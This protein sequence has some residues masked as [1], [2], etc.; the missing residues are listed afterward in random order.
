MPQLLSLEGWQQGVR[1]AWRSARRSP[2][3]F[4]LAVLIVGL[5]IAASTTVFSV[6]SPLLIRPLP[7]EDAERLVLVEN[8]R[9]GEGLAGVASR[10]SNLRDFR[11]RARSFEALGA[12]N[13]FSNQVGYHLLGSGGPERLR[14]AEVTANFLDVIGVSPVIG[15][16]FT[17]EEG[18]LG[19]E[20]PWPNIAKVVILSHALWLRRFG[21]D[22]SVVGSTVNINGVGREVVGILPEDFD[23]SEIFTP[24]RPV[25]ILAPW[26]VTDFGEEF[27]NTLT[28]V[29]RLRPGASVR[30]AQAELGVTLAAL[31]SEDPDRRDLAAVVSGLQERISRPHRPAL[32][33]LGAAAALLM[34]MVCANLSGLFLARSPGR[35]REMAVRQA[36][37]ATR[38]RL[39]RQLLVE[40]L[41]ITLVGATVGVAWAIVATHFV[42]GWS[43]LDMPMLSGVSVNR[44]AL[45]FSATLATTAAIAVG[46]VPA[47]QVSESGGAAVLS[48][49]RRGSSAGPRSQR[50]R[51]I[52]IVAEVAIACVLLVFGGLIARS[53]HE[54]T[55]VHPGFEAENLIAWEI[56]ATEGFGFAAERWSGYYDGIIR[57]VAA[58]PG[59]QA[60]SFV[61]ILPM[62]GNR[63]SEGTIVGMSYDEGES[64]SFFPRIVDHRYLEV[65]GIPL[66]EGRNFT[67]DDDDEATLVTI[68]NE[69]AARRWF[70][71]APA[72]GKHLDYWRGETEVIGIVADV[73]H[74]GLELSSGAE[75]YFPF[76]QALTLGTLHLVVRTSLP[77]ASVIEAV[78]TAIHDADPL[79]PTDEF[80]TLASVVAQTTSSRRFT[81][82]VLVA[83]TLSALLLAALG[84]YAVFSQV[85]SERR[86]EISIRMALGASSSDVRT[87]LLLQSGRLSIIGV[88]LGVGAA[89][90]TAQ[91]A[92]HVL[93]R[94]EPADPYTIA[95]AIVALATISIGSTFVPALRA[96]R[97]ESARVLRDQGFV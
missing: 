43:G 64:E 28:M 2:A 9:P 31:A 89:V 67:P 42:S 58:V 77:P 41:S 27:G 44:D 78:R 14:A 40:S 49:G 87:S 61:D 55:A 45:L 60:A 1:Q 47:L 72:I 74:R 35:A 32:L 51:E 33:L 90:A 11:E 88:V 37:G 71:G 38:A 3:F 7:L 34:I 91:L 94:V 83:F 92:D 6:M 18:Q 62:S 12:F 76:P 84:I 17:E 23:F 53:F 97:T 65:M 57:S 16:N 19:P 73:K 22:P 59:V 26:P 96:S 82:Q 54:V 24:S 68:I 80:R 48:G 8:D 75:A 20:G 5:G 15:R 36:L 69:T 30:S 81:L 39:A 85:V 93:F 56:R 4:V 86:T 13:A 25:E 46:L 63:S 29:G 79:L 66:L 52:L 10:T 21:E 70:A 95:T 50:L